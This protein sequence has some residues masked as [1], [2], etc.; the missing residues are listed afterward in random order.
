MVEVFRITATKILS[1][2]KHDFENISTPK[3][4]TIYKNLRKNQ[5]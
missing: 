3:N 4:H 1:S 5:V 2:F